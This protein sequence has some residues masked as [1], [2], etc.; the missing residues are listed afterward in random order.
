MLYNKTKNNTGNVKLNKSK[1]KKMHFK[2]SQSER[3]E[4][5]EVFEIKVNNKVATV[6]L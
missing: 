2:R 3:K 5:P 4:G 1:F 6:K